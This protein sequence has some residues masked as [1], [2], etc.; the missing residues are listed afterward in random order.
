M[1]AIAHSVIGDRHLAEDAAQETF[2]RAYNSIGSY[3]LKRPFPTWLLSIAAHYCIDILRRRR[4]NLVSIYDLPK[5]EVPDHSPGIE[6][7]VSQR[8][9]GDRVRDLLEC[10]NPIDRAAI[11]LY[12]WYEYS[13]KEICETLS[14]SESAL[15]SRLF[16]AR[17]TMAKK[18]TQAH[19]D[20]L[21][22]DNLATE[23]VPA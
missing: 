1:V 3:D 19:S 16:R 12:Y 21:A 13:Y 23:Y 8:E 11:V 5:P 7:Q 22:A 4:F 6:T 15:K 10:L 20:G 18:W 9:E 14:I 17:K 2:L